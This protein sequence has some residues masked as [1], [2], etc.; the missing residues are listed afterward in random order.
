MPKLYPMSK[1]FS[2]KM[3]AVDESC[4]RKCLKTVEMNVTKRFFLG[5]AQRDVLSRIG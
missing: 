4:V 5:K 1:I 2:Y 3:T